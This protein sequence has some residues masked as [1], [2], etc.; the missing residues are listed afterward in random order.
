MDVPDLVSAFGKIETIDKDKAL[1]IASTIIVQANS[2]PSATKDDKLQFNEFMSTLEGLDSDTYD[3]DKFQRLVKRTAALNRLSADTQQ[4][5]MNMYDA[6]ENGIDLEESAA[7]RA[8]AAA[9]A[10][11]GGGGV[12]SVLPT[13][14]FAPKPQVR[15]ITCH[16]CKKVFGVPTGAT[17]VAC[18]HC[19]TANQVPAQAATGNM[20]TNLFTSQQPQ[21][22]A[23][24]LVVPP[25]QVS[26]PSA[27]QPIARPM[28]T[29]TP[30]A[31]V[32]MQAP[33]PTARPASVAGGQGAL[34][35]AMVQPA[36][37]PTAQQ[38]PVHQQYSTRT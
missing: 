5:A 27:S 13:I 32:Q 2:S 22:V 11:R 7:E 19:R 36:Q 31:T 29:A 12:F 23:G 37:Y 28:P 25:S 14:N 18:P 26:G 6:V 9:P 33:M 38:Y 1:Q 3:F 15:K 35:V 17:V 16:A 21:N 20:F 4:R 10:N 34:P 24:Q 30:A 8:P